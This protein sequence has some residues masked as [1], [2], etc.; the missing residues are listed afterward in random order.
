M[1][2]RHVKRLRHCAAKET[3]RL[4]QM[5]DTVMKSTYGFWLDGKEQSAKKTMSVENPATGEEL[6]QVASC[7]TEDV[8]SAV[9]SAKKAFKGWSKMH[10]RERGRIL[11]RASDIL[12]ERLDTLSQ[13]ETLQT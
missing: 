4:S 13:M 6:C 12:R 2:P 1:L 5:K 9:A 8:N 7:S 3:R 10:P 11:I